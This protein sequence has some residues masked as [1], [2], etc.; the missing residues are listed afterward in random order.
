VLVGEEV[1]Q[2]AEVASVCDE[3]ALVKVEKGVH[4]LDRADQGLKG[5]GVLGE[6]SLETVVPGVEFDIGAARDGEEF[7]GRSWDDD[8]TVC[9]LVE[10]GEV[11]AVL[12]GHGSINHQAVEIQCLQV[13]QAM[14]G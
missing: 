5:V 1:I 8:F 7:R 13:F 14:L 11:D 12:D 3:R 10:A 9:E 4:D 6:V 2:L